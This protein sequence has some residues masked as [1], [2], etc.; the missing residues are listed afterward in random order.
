MK[1]VITAVLLLFVVASFVYLVAGER[2][3]DPATPTVPSSHPTVKEEEGVPDQPSELVATRATEQHAA[4]T[5]MTAMPADR[6]ANKPGAPDREIIAYY[7]HRTQRC[8]TC[9]NMEA[10]AEEALRDGLPD[11][12]ESGELEWRAVNVE[13]PENEHF[14]EE[15]RLI[16]SALVMVL[17]ENGEQKQSKNL[18]RVWELVR[19]ERGFK[20]YVR[21][22]AF[23]YLEDGS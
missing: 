23:A 7:F 11:A 17:L 14:V 12:F 22:E 3:R 5:V 21:D 8:R 2:G 16:A 1:N 19:D 6:A 13:E 9:L 18:E 15:Y 4:H 20:D 10:Y